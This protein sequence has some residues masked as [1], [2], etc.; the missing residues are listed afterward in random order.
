[1]PRP[2]DSRLV[3]F[4]PINCKSVN[5]RPD[6]SMSIDSRLVDSR[7]INEITCSQISCFVNFR[8]VFIDDF[9]QRNDT[10]L[11]FPMKLSDWTI[12]LAIQ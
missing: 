2:V 9:N 12:Q 5:D 3:D 7:P 4:R 11:S 8:Q 10:A 6:N 1:M